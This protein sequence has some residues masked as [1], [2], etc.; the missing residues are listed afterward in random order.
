M[1]SLWA[2]ISFLLAVVVTQ[3]LYT[4]FSDVFGRMFPLYLAFLL[5]GVGSIVFAVA[6]SMAVIILGRVLQG[7]GGGGLDVLGEIIVADITSLKERPL[8]LGLLA[9]PMALGSILGPIV[10]ALFA[11]YVSWRWIGW[12][13]L[14]LV[15]VGFAFCF[16]FL[17]LK[18][19]DQS[20]Y[21]KLK[22]VDWFGM[23]LF[24]IG[25][26]AFIL[27]L[28]WGGSMFP[29]QSWKTILPLVL[30]VALLV[31]L[32]FYESR[33][34]AP[35][36]PYRLFRSPTALTTLVGSF[37]HGLIVYCML[38]YLPIYLQAVR[39]EAPIRG[40]ILAFPLG[41]T[42]VTFSVLSAIAVQL[43]RRYRWNIWLGWI[44]TAC[45]LGLMSMLDR[46]STIAEQ[47]GFQIIA[48]LGI[49]ALYVVLVIP[50]QASA[51]SVDDTG[52]A[53]GM[54]VFFRLLGAVVG[55]AIGSAAFNNVFDQHIASNGPLPPSAAMFQNSSEA[56]GA[57]PLL[58][59]AD[60]PP[61]TMA[62]ILDA[63]TRAIRATWL[64]MAGLGAVGFVTSLAMKELTLEKEEMGRQHFEP[65]S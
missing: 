59:T 56:I 54:L 13:N 29:W 55:L 3:P 17:R 46:S 39:L 16:F 37:V 60:L 41:L 53:V 10:G 27:P 1:E 20:V 44:F 42:V 57:I 2:N 38:A 5:F 48:G 50:M 62:V 61:E 26:T 11:E 63:Y 34:R 25:L 51:P 58:R 31:A 52:L 36:F 23:L 35:I 40:A 19:I 65:S 47:S 8:Y 22:S 21:V 45:G 30:G 49:G 24:S 33:P 7:L 4:S 9:V 64:I 32:G 12:I 18:P 28:S 15:V 6:D 43:S 14:P